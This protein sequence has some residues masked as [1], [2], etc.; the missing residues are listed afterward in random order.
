VFAAFRYPTYA[1]ITAMSSHRVYWDRAKALLNFRK[2][3][4]FFDDAAAVFDDPLAVT[5]HDIDHSRAEERWVTLG[6]VHAALLHVVHTLDELDEDTTWI[7]IISARH[8]TADERRQ[9]ES[10][11]YRIQE[12]VMK[13]DADP[14][15]WVRGRFYREG[16]AIILP[17]HVD[18]DIVDTLNALAK[19]R[20]VTPSELGNSLLRKAMAEPGLHH[21]SIS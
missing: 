18:D 12:A 10:G 13:R 4:V 9:Y 1:R 21:E 16:A 6:E 17:V 11:K 2:H 7:R 14:S 5:R 15:V 8:P 19:Q 20:G 3:A